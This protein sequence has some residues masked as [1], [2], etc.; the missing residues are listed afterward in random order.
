MKR[1]ILLLAVSAMLFS[2]APLYRQVATIQSDNVELLDNGK[3]S[4]NLD[5]IS[6]NYDFWSENGN[7]LF[8]IHNSSDKDIFI[9]MSK[10]FFIRN[11]IAN[12]YF[13]NSSRIVSY[14]LNASKTT[15]GMK[16]LGATVAGI[17]LWPSTKSASIA[18]AASSGTSVSKGESIEY[19]EKSI[20][21][22]PS[23][24]S[25]VIAKFTLADAPYRECG[26]IRDPKGKET[27]IFRFNENN[28]PLTF[29]NRLM[30]VIDGKE[31]LFTN[32]FFV[33][34]MQNIMDEKC[35]ESAGRSGC[36]NDGITIY[37]DIFS[38]PNR[39]YVHYTKPFTDTDRVSSK[40]TSYTNSKVN[41]TKSTNSKEKSKVDN[42]PS[43][44]NKTKK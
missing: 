9:D 16:S 23:K 4:A 11:G 12:D 37:S 43:K 41:N 42:Q 28:S 14:N 25:K 22:I 34:Q 36:N 35:F 39:Y 31:S 6:I 30:L 3:Y 40:P 10:S 7:V 24:S 19:V 5:E 29:E 44:K 21:C 38:G 26:F 33:N 13:S 27:S 8:E 17:S 2:C 15:Y 1:L 20:I 18:A 32:K